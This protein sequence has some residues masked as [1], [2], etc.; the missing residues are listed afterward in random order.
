[1]IKPPFQ[2]ATF[3]NTGEDDPYGCVMNVVA[4]LAGEPTTAEPACTNWHLT[5]LAQTFNDKL[6]MKFAPHTREFGTNIDGTVRMVGVATPEQATRMLEVAE[7]L[8]NTSVVKRQDS[9]PWLRSV[10][11]LYA[12]NKM[13]SHGLATAIVDDADTFDEAV[14]SMLIILEDFHSTFAD[15]LTPKEQALV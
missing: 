1:M 11:A 10:T 13:G 8:V 14:T 5:S 7:M 9:I 15:Q 2:L 12:P 3:F 6:L 4:W